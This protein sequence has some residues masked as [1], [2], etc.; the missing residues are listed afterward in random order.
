MGVLRAGSS[1]DKWKLSKDTLEKCILWGVEHFTVPFTLE[2]YT[3]YT[4]H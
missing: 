2:H 1:T 3:L 4:I